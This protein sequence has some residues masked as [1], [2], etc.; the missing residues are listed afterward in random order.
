MHGASY[1]SAG[2][3]RFLL[4]SISLIGPLWFYCSRRDEK[5]KK[6]NEY[7]GKK[8]EAVEKIQEEAEETEEMTVTD[9]SEDGRG[10]GSRKEMD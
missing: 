6:E 3:S 8:Y 9:V 4:S 2:S 5:E 10:G 7:E 1:A